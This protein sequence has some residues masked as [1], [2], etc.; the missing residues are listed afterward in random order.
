LAA[1]PE[2]CKGGKPQ[3]ANRF[4]QLPFPVQAFGL[5]LYR[6]MEVALPQAATIAFWFGIC[7]RW[8]PLNE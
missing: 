8:A 5:L 7:L 2:W 3:R 1:V 4:R 6:Q